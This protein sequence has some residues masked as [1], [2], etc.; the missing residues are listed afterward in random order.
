M[1]MLYYFLTGFFTLLGALALLR[2]IELLFTGVG[3]L[4]VQFLIGILM[5]VFAGGCLRKARNAMTNIHMGRRTHV[6]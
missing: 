4:P 2:T 6:R 5:L 3:M 1:R